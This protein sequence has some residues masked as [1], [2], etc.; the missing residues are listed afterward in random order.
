MSDPGRD[1][2]DH[3]ML[4]NPKMKRTDVTDFTDQF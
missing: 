3:L 1:I 2:S 4:G